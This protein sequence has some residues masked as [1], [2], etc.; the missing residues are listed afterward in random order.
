MIGKIDAFRLEIA[1]QL[2]EDVIIAGFLEVGFDD[3]LG[4][5]LRG[6]ATQP[7]LFRR[8]KSKQLVTAGIRLLF[9]LFVIRELVLKTFFAIVECAHGTGQLLL[10]KSK[11]RSLAIACYGL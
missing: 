4:I 9:Q 7:Q 10:N 11:N 6:I 8:P 3:L 1:F 2:P 5:G